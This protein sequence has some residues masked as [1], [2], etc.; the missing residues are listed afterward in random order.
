[1]TEETFTL[2]DIDDGTYQI[3]EHYEYKKYRV[4]VSI[5]S[6][7]VPEGKHGVVFVC[8]ANNWRECYLTLRWLTKL[9][10]EESGYF[11]SVEQENWLT[12]PEDILT[13]FLE[14]G[15]DED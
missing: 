8:I 7:E 13:E 9:I 3:E 5:Q 15:P 1:M 11:I 14:G 12:I 10:D 4:I 2:K 6:D